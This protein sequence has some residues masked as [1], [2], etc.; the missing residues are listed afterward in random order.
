[1]D[2]I[3]NIP[4]AV[5]SDSVNSSVLTLDLY[6]PARSS[7]DK[8]LP[9]ILIIHG[10]SYQSGSKESSEGLCRELT[11]YGFVAVAFDYR[12]GWDNDMGCSSDPEGLLVAEYRALQDARAAF[13]FLA[14]KSNG[15]SLDTNWFFVGGRSAGGATALNVC[16]KDEQYVNSRR[17][18]LVQT[19]GNIDR[20][21]ND[22]EDHFSIKGVMN[23]WG[24]IEETNLIQADNAIPF[25]GF[26]GS[27][28]ILVPIEAGNFLGCSSFPSSYGTLSIYERLS[29]LAI[30]A[31]A[32]L[33]DG[34]G[35]EPHEIY[36][37]DFIAGNTACFFH[38]IISGNPYSGLFTGTTHSCR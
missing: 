13:R 7:I 22:L 27:D 35:H 5:Y 1:M 11:K 25:I 12:K 20:S 29:E 28:D 4:Y 21:G 10:G 18:G 36:T 9:L 24:S 31:V 23:G 37:D 16:Y 38:G 33:L 8:K 19:F 15:Y 3:K 17:S 26:H 32:H 14:H 6:F 34:G 2:T 30:P